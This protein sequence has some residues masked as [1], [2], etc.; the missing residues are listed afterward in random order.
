MV[1]EYGPRLLRLLIPVGLAASSTC[2]AAPSAET[3]A[4]V[5]QEVV[6][7]AQKRSENLQDVPI[8]IT[9]VNADELHDRA[10]TDSSQLQYISPSLQTQGQQNS[11]G[12]TSF[13]VRGIGTAVYAPYIEQSVAI[14]LDGISLAQS[15]LGIVRLFDIDHIEVL[16][17]PQGTLFG[18]N[19]SAGVVN[20]VTN[21]PRLGSYDATAHVDLGFGSAPG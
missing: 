14:V 11:N 1:T 3:D 15:Q 9:V 7:T 17:G 4:F 2:V 5:L 13:S 16:R 21:R 19:A 18:K 10:F 8:A 20:I 6:V 12:A